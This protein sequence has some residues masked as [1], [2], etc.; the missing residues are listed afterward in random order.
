V[1]P[2]VKI[3]GITNR[4]DAR[5]CAGE[6]ADAL[7]FI[8]HKASPRYIEPE[9][10]SVIIEDLPS[11]IIP[12]GV[13]VN[14]RRVEVEEIIRRTGIRLIQFSGDERPGDCTGYGLPCWKA[15][16]IRDEAGVARISEY[17]VDAVLLDGA[18]DGR[19]GGTGTPP[20]YAIARLISSKVP[21]V[22]AG[23]ISPENVSDTIV[24]TRPFGI[25]VNSGVESSPGKKSG[26]RVRKLFQ[27]I[28]STCSTTD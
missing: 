20:D 8:F 18:S 14:L 3:C 19:Y 5:I 15:F 1:R 28:T 4:E 25:D 13:V 12:V 24:Q 11:G 26:E 16:R 2:L 10:A 27:Q 22:I 21:M 23:G 7:G 9:E 17:Q 6:G